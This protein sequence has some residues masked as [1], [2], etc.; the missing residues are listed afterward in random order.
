MVHVGSCTFDFPV[1]IARENVLALVR[2]A[3]YSAFTIHMRIFNDC[4][5]VLK[6]KFYE[7]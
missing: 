4:L 6:S 3:I 5:V 1:L 7:R 2:S